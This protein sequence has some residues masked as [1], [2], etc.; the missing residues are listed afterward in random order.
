[1]GM[2]VQGALKWSC[3]RDT[4]GD[5]TYRVSWL[6]R[7]NDVYDGPAH[8]I[9]ASGLPQVGSTWQAGNDYDVWAFCTP[10]TSASPL[11]SKERGY[12]WV[13]E[14]TFTTKPQNRC[15]N[16]SIE[17]PLQ[18]PAEIS[19]SFVKYS[20]EV[21]KDKDD[22]PIETSSHEII[23]GPVVEFD[24]NRATVSIKGNILTLPLEMFTDMIDKV[25]DAT[26]W[27]LAKRKVKLSNV[28][29]ARVLYGTCFFYYTVTYEFDIDFETFDRTTLDEGTRVLTKGGDKDNKNDFELYKDVNGENTRVFLNGEGEKLGDGE[30]PIEIEIKYYEEANFLQLGIPTSL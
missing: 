17:N 3:S 10:E 16:A 22:N 27:G 12:Y 26:L 11:Q 6:V 7:S 5:R 29:W 8:A 1:M 30:D 28:S 18:E 23:R 4:K 2:S 9:T 15:Q 21:D 20:K 14:N 13:V 25:N 19:G 24:Q